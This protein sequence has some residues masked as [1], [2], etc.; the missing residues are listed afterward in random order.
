MPVQQ[1]SE[2]TAV[3]ARRGKWSQAG[4]PHKG[5]RCVDVD[6]RAAVDHVCQMC[7]SQAVRFVHKTESIYRRYAI[8]DEAMQR[9]AAA[10]L[11][12]WMAL[13]ATAPSTSTVAPLR[14]G[15]RLRGRATG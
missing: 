4:V 5:W 8:V 3:A 9:E 2:D 15:N 13:P 10:R 12:A 6:D 7:E 1:S 14:H 11:D